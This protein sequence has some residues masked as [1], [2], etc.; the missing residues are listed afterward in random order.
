MFRFNV[1]VLSLTLSGG[2]I[3]QGEP[4]PDQVIKTVDPSIAPEQLQSCGSNATVTLGGISVSTAVD[5]CPLLVIVRPGH[6][7]TVSRPGSETF[8][9][10]VKNVPIR[11]INFECQTRW[12]LFIPISSDCVSVLW[13][14]AGV[15]THYQQFPCFEQEGP[16]DE[17]EHDTG[18]GHG[19]RSSAQG[20]R[21]KGHRPGGQRIS[22]R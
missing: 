17:P 14:N 11:L 1:I 22:Q 2:L 6:D 7:T 19:R 18:A 8:T 16:G 9:R 13:T 4:C 21:G 10:P 12:F 15:V 20:H 5:L 3:A